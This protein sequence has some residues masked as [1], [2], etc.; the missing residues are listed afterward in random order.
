MTIKR[1]IV[2]CQE[3]NLFL[4]MPEEH[5]EHDV[6][7][8]NEIEEEQ[9]AKLVNRVINKHYKDNITVVENRECTLCL[10]KGKVLLLEPDY[11]S[12]DLCVDCLKILSDKLQ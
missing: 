5:K 2:F 8:W 4:T 11:G 3:C 10:H 12:L 1:T 6:T 7:T 9:Y